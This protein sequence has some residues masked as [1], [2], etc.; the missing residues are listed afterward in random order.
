MFVIVVTYGLERDTDNDDHL[1]GE[2]EET[3]KQKKDGEDKVSSSDMDFIGMANSLDSKLGFKQ[4]IIN[5]K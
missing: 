4:L 1:S 5:N 2:R 3:N